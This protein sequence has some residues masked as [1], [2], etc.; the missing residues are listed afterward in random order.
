[1]KTVKE[2]AL[3]IAQIMQDLK[4]ENVTVLDVSRLN[5]W[6][7]F[8]IIV[9]VNSSTHSSGLKKQIKDYV[10]ENDMEITDSS[11]TL[12][13]YHGTKSLTIQEEL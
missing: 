1:M 2:K 10:K 8:F 9:T 6:T 5:S 4:G 3:E 7:D 11:V 13:M 12:S